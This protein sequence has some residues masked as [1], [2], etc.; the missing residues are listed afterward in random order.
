MRNIEVQDNVFS[1]D[2]IQRTQNTHL[3]M[4]KF[5]TQSEPFVGDRPRHNYHRS[6]V[7]SS[8]EIKMM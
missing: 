2:C 7:Q 5:H 6:S 1:R 3:I 8:R 4:C